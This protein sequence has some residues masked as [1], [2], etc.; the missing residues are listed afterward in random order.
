M[1]EECL[2][3]ILKRSNNTFSNLSPKPYCIL[4]RYGTLAQV[5]SFVGWVKLA[6]FSFYAIIIFCILV[7]CML[8]TH[9]LVLPFLRVQHRPHQVLYYNQM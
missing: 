5:I 6:D 9:I 8:L 1:A 4:R 7:L 2:N 3:L